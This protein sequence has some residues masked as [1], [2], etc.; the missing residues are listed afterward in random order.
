LLTGQRSIA[1]GENRQV[2]WGDGLI[3]QLETPQSNIFHEKI[4]PLGFESDILMLG[5]CPKYLLKP[6]SW[7]C[8]LTIL[9]HE[10]FFAR[11]SPSAINK[12]T[13]L[14]RSQDHPWLFANRHTRQN[15]SD[16]S[17]KGFVI[18]GTIHFK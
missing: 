7:H 3:V 8:A 15:G 10:C 4:T 2:R 1:S 13:C 14:T 12:Q 16:H 17:A 11:N 18:N 5:K 6:S 9:Q